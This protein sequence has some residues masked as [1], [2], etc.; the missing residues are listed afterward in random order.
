MSVAAPL[1]LR[2]VIG[3]DSE[4]LTRSSSVRAGLASRA[5]SFCLPPRGYPTRRSPGGPRPAVR[6]WWIGAPVRRRRDG[7]PAR[8]AAQWAAIR[9]RRHGRATG[10]WRAPTGPTEVGRVIRRIGRP[11]TVTVDRGYG[12]ASGERSARFRNPDRRDPPQGPTRQG[13][14]SPRAPPCVPRRSSGAPAAKPG[15]SASTGGTAHD[16]MTSTGPGSGPDTGPGPQPGQD[17]RPGPLIDHGR[18]HHL[19]SATTPTHS[20]AAG[21]FQVEVSACLG[22]L[23]ATAQRGTR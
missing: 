15:S 14:P 9:D 8:S 17:R 4:A 3:P 6:R 11:R 5:R 1:V 7:S 22:S 16:L 23:E 13:P 2:E 10:R 12:E 21:L 20:H 18:D 19:A